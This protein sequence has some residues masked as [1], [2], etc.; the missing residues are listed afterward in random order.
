[1]LPRIAP[2]K[3]GK[4]N[5]VVYD[6]NM[7]RI[8][9]KP[10]N[11]CAREL[12][13]QT[14][15]IIASLWESN[16]GSV[17]SF[18]HPSNHFASQFSAFQTDSP[19]RVAFCPKF[20]DGRPIMCGRQKSLTADWGFLDFGLV[21]NTKRPVPPTIP[22]PQM[23]MTSFLH[24]LLQWPPVRSPPCITAFLFGARLY[25]RDVAVCGLHPQPSPFLA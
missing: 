8:R 3:H 6:G 14:R 4:G 25:S 16:L 21:P 19:A 15:G 1:M 13:R 20:C 7:W 10:R 9:G 23:Q 18:A 12:L 5:D 2:A 11:Q 22:R 17:L 24:L